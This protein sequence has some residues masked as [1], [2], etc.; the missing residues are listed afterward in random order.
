MRA[1]E[2][3]RLYRTFGDT[4]AWGMRLR[5]TEDGLT[6]QVVPDSATVTMHIATNPVTIIAG[7]P[8]GDSKG[9]FTFPTATLNVEVDNVTFEV[10]VIDAGVEYTIA[11]GLI[12]ESPQIA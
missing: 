6:F 9:W 8:R 5:T 2:D 3:R 12:E 4:D 10:Q 11:R 1:S 7:V